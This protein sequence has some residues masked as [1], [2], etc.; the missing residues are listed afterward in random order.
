M[1]LQVVIPSQFSAPGIVDDHDCAELGSLDDGL[2][3]AAILNSPHQEVV[4][5]A[6]VVIVAAPEECV[7]VKQEPHS[8]LRH[9][10]SENLLSHGL[11]NQHD[12]EKKTQLRKEIELIEVDEAGAVDRAGGSELQIS[13][14]AL[15]RE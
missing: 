13:F 1:K 3:L 2:S 15:A 6:L 7:S 10:P 8:V 9:R 12:L 4:D 11:G 14:A 5:R